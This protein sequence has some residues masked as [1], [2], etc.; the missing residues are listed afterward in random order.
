LEEFY[1]EDFP[2]GQTH[3]YCRYELTRDQVDAYASDF[4]PLLGARRDADDTSPSASPWQLCAL[5]MRLNYD[6][7]MHRCAARGAPGID[8]VRW[9][10]PVLAGE[11][12]SARYTVRSARL[13]RSKPQLGLVQYYYELL[14]DDGQPT[15]SQLNS[16]MMQ[17]RSPRPSTP[18]E[19]RKLPIHR[20]DDTVP[21]DCGPRVELGQFDFP[22]ETILDFARLY[23]PQP[24]HVDPLAATKGPFGALAASG[25]HTAASWARGYAQCFN[26]GTASL[27]RPLRLLWIRPLRWRK[28]VFA[29][30]PVTF[31]FAATHVERFSADIAIVTCNNR[32]IDAIGAIVFEFTLGMAV[33]A[34]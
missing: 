15:M 20:D 9:L 22:A 33:K 11:T 16:V 5:L 21:N 29:G 12:L 1:F 17:V 31:D 19:E 34:A 18:D 3:Q 8:E 6:G 26:A 23:D 2:V 32:G 25:W 13:S 27:P 28:P 30:H 24:F 14:G 7:W 10:R 4:D